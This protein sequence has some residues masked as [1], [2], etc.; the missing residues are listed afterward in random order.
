MK[1]PPSFLAPSR[2]S[3]FPSTPSG[4]SRFL[5]HSTDFYLSL[6]SSF[7]FSCSL[8]HSLSDYK[9]AIYYWF[10]FGFKYQYFLIYVFMFCCTRRIFSN[11][12][13]CAWNLLLLSENILVMCFFLFLFK[14]IYE[15]TYFTCH[16][17]YYTKFTNKFLLTIILNYQP[18]NLDSLV[19]KTKANE[20]QISSHDPHLPLCVSNSCSYLGP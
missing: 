3:S 7:S 6:L 15:F 1:A 14:Y 16:F 9:F 12:L 20:M 4:S 11:Q 8:F 13:I 5:S 19:Y 18:S 17:F 2:R 10:L